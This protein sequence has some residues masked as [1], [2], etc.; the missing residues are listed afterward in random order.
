MVPVFARRAL[1][2]AIERKCAIAPNRSCMVNPAPNKP[3]RCIPVS[4][5][6]SRVAST[7]LTIGSG[8]SAHGAGVCVRRLHA[9]PRHATSS[10]PGLFAAPAG[11]ECRFQ[12]RQRRPVFGRFVVRLLVM[13]RSRRATEADIITSSAS[14]GHSHVERIEAI[15][16]GSTTSIRSRSGPATRS[17]NTGTPESPGVNCRLASGIAAGSGP[18]RG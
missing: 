14:A 2:K 15:G 1:E 18:T 11:E 4:L 3:T 8:S 13:T 7:M 9:L 12:N 10:W 16:V 6:T 5:T 17:L